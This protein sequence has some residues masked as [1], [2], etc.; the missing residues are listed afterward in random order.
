MQTGLPTLNNAPRRKKRT[1]R[2]LLP[3]VA[4]GGSLAAM[5]AGA[6]E[7]GDIAVQSRLGQPLRASIAYAL[8][9]HEKMNA[10]CVTLGV[11]APSSGLPGIGRATISIADG[12]ILL[13][14]SSPI[15]EPMVAAR[16][17]VRCPYTA[18]L[19][20]EYMMFID[21]ASPE[22]AKQAAETPAA[23][24]VP[25]ARKPEPDVT[26][27]REAQPGVSQAP[28]GKATRY[29][30]QAGDSLSEIA[31]R[32]E[33]RPAG[34][35]SAVDTIFRANPDA[36]INNDRNRLKAGSWLTIPSFDGSEPLIAPV[37]VATDL[38]AG[39]NAP[40]AYGLTSVPPVETAPPAPVE[41][42]T[43]APVA[44]AI[45]MPAETAADT[46]S[47]GRPEP[48]VTENDNPFVDGAETV[49]ET[50]VIP[51]TEIEGPAT[52]STSPNVTTA[53]IS[54]DAPE[55]SSWLMWLAGSGLA[56]IIGLLLFG[57][58]VRSR[59]VDPVF[60]AV[61]VRPERPVSD[62]ESD[63]IEVIT[64]AGYTLDDD[65]PTSENFS[66][67]ADLVMG[68]GLEDSADVDM[69]VAQDFGFAAL[70][71]QALD[72][73][74]PFEP[75]LEV[76]PSDTGIFG[77]AGQDSP[78]IVEE[79]AVEESDGA[80]PDDDEYDMSVM[81]DATKMPQPDYITQRDLQAVEVG[82]ADEHTSTGAFTGTETI[83]TDADLEILEQDYEDELTATQ[84]LNKEI[85]RVAAEIA[86]DRAKA[87][88]M[89][90]DLGSEL[91][92]DATA[93]LPSGDDEYLVETGIH[94]AATI[95]AATVE[96][97]AA[98][99]DE[100]AEME[101]DGGEVDTKAV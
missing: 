21:P 90:D 20:R 86:A 8:G 73:E 101:I 56:L 9:P 2:T 75:E 83:V 50:V 88:A 72:L 67:D 68:T 30:V 25:A 74:L 58:L 49:A 7:L 97:P 22:F 89:N 26:R 35:W 44:E 52:R 69:E 98:E 14:G 33:N 99:N 34:L 94:D 80:S 37:T 60:D 40:S 45:D 57:R 95:E 55:T 53:V 47:D 41:T 81:L 18:N 36:F 79:D 78:S 54:T 46:S 10:S 76:D 31:A 91:D 43:P 17:D 3:L 77:V 65:A 100:T 62:L 93:L 12:T 42:T 64:H 63:G 27:P 61:P 59:P 19:S 15:R 85:E 24:P 29:R 92:D 13:T 51:D 70:Q 71:E 28:I 84:A 5:P 48:A 96:M 6:I 39:S 1:H 32:I 23:A 38:S 4:V 87:E 82:P 16:I 11:G 66:L